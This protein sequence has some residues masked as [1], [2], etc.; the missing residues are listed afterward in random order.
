MVGAL[1]GAKYVLSGVNEH[2]DVETY[3]CL[4]CSLMKSQRPHHI[5]SSN[6]RRPPQHV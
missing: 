6:W 1:C 4:D 5:T 3:V 2:C